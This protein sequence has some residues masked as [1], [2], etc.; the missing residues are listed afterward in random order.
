VNEDVRTN[1]NGTAEKLLSLKNLNNTIAV[2]RQIIVPPITPKPKNSSNKEFS[3][4][5]FVLLFDLKYSCAVPGPNPK[6]FEGMISDARLRSSSLACVDSD[7][8]LVLNRY[9][10]IPRKRMNSPK[11]K[12]FTV[13]MILL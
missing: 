9:C 4:I 12:T 5:N 3:T 1:K 13:A 11:M 6:G 10:S 7:P 8:S 2:L